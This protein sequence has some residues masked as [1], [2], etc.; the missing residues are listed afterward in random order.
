MDSDSPPGPET[1][2]SQSTLSFLLPRVPNPGASG[3]SGATVA[4][5]LHSWDGTLDGSPDREERAREARPLVRGILGGCRAAGTAVSSPSS[6]AG[7]RGGPGQSGCTWRRRSL[8]A[9]QLQQT[10]EGVR[11]MLPGRPSPAKT[12]KDTG[13]GAHAEKTLRAAGKKGLTDSWDKTTKSDITVTLFTGKMVVEADL[14]QKILERHTNAIDFDG[15]H[16]QVS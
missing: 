10:G 7:R 13:A 6:L 14:C 8:L 11:S 4:D 15:V 16:A 9:P 12:A 1:V 5:G 2:P 3:G